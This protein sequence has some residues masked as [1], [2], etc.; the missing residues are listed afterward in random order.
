MTRTRGQREDYLQSSA[1]SWANGQ[2]GGAPNFIRT[3]IYSQSWS[4]S[5]TA[6][7]ARDEPR[8]PSH[9]DTCIWLLGGNEELPHSTAVK[10]ENTSQGLLGALGDSPVSHSFSATPGAREISHTRMHSSGLSAGRRCCRGRVCTPLP[11]LLRRRSQ[12]TR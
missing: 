2:G 4:L 5:A 10:S 11:R 1:L 12:D 9:F 6:C 7:R 8:M 3:R